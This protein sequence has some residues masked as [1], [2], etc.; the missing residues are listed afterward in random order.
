MSHFAHIDVNG[1]VTQIIV[2]EQDFINS[3]A[4]G[5]PA[6]WVQTSF[7]T[8]GGVHYGLDGKP[9]GKPGLRKN[10]AVIGGI[11]DLA[12][13]AFYGIKPSQSWI[14]NEQTCLWEPPIPCPNDGNP[15]LW[16]ELQ[17]NWV[18]ATK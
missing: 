2:A 12:R 7:N 13:D 3:G 11:Y 1:F 9:D 16:D 17:L 6:E 15:Y 4:V 8:Y 14:L 10:Y 18:L 5:N